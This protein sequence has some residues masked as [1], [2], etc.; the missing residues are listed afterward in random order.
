MDHGNI[1][2]KTQDHIDLN[3]FHRENDRKYIV[4]ETNSISGQ[5]SSGISDVFGSALWLVDYS[6][7]LASQVFSRIEFTNPSSQY[8]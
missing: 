1:V 4:G 6:L 7:Y 8:R 3:N 5:G 2:D